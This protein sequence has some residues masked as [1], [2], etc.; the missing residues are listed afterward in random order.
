[1]N[2]FK[3][4]SQTPSMSYL[5]VQ[6]MWKGHKVNLLGNSVAVGLHHLLH[7]AHILSLTTQTNE[8]S[9]NN[10]LQKRYENRMWEE[11]VGN[12]QPFRTHTNFSCYTK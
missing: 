2:S 12:L 4:N 10:K 9:K 6:M 7:A 3:M 11:R 1:M 8:I 5:N